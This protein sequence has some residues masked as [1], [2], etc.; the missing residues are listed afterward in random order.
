MLGMNWDNLSLEQSEEMRNMVREVAQNPR[1]VKYETI[2]KEFETEAEAMK[3]YE[4]LIFVLGGAELN[5]RGD[6]WVVTSRG[7]Y[8]YMGA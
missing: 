5:K 4:A 3:L 2:P 1:G 7:Y 6:K 8:Y